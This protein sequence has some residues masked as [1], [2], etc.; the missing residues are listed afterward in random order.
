MNGVQKNTML[1]E[2]EQLGIV[3]D[4]FEVAEAKKQGNSCLIGK[5]WAGK[6]VNRDGFITVFKRIWRTVGEVDFKEI[7][8]NVWIFEFSKESDK[9]RVLKGRPWSFDR[10]L[11]ALTEFDGGIPSSLWNF[12][13]SP[14]WI[15]IHDMPLICMTKSIGSKIGESL[16]ILEAV[17]TE[18]EGVEWGS[19]LRVRVIIDIQK[20]L[21]RGRSLT[22]AGKS[23]WVN[24][25]YENLPI[26][27]F[28]CGRIVH[29]EGGCPKRSQKELKKEWGVW[30]RAEKY[31]KQAMGRGDARN[32]AGRY[33]TGGQPMDG[34]SQAEQE[35]HRNMGNPTP[36]HHPHMA[37]ANNNKS[38]VMAATKMAGGG[39]SGEAN[40]NNGRFYGEKFQDF[41][42]NNKSTGV[43][44][45]DEI[46]RE[47]GGKQVA[48]AEQ[49]DMGKM[50]I[51]EEQLEAPNT[52][53]I[54]GPA[55]WDSK[56]GAGLD[57][58]KADST[59]EGPKDH[60]T[61][62][63]VKDKAQPANTITAQ[64]NSQAMEPD[65]RMAASRGANYEQVRNKNSVAIWKKVSRVEGGETDSTGTI[66]AFMGKRKA[67]VGG[68][69]SDDQRHLKIR[70]WE[71]YLEEETETNFE[72]FETE[73]VTEND[74]A[75]AAMQPR[76]QP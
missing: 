68:L 73:M 29:G 26:F 75:E 72:D 22:I 60:V 50:L 27:C 76:P 34:G 30:L 14:F 42:A 25:K 57:F 31:N 74:K 33:N 6:R 21:E 58:S 59:K 36:H 20:P 48:P 70:K 67:E 61:A 5:I 52:D 64:P 51:N 16:G 62:P 43:N 24:F 13:S 44:E 3:V 47:K 37:S 71:D 56:K 4:D 39:F 7:Q 8:P 11:L 54:T 15:Q 46:L 19:V 45:G 69:I 9:Y 66:P 40:G 2:G 18:G 53:F 55:A 32:H 41:Q 63:S 65:F 17:D 10:S 38:G 1:S 12:T 35:N 49:G 28:N 23:H